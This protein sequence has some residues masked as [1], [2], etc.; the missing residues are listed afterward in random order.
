MNFDFMKNYEFFLSL[1]Y[2]T[3]LASVVTL[4]I[5]QI[6]KAIL[7][8]RNVIFPEMEASH[9]DSILSAVG[10][11]VALIAYTG[12]YIG[13]EL[14]LKHAITFDEELITGLLSGGAL[15]LTISKGFYTM[16]HQYRNKKTVYEKLRYAE[17]T[18]KKLQEPQII[19]AKEEAEAYAKNAFLPAENNSSTSKRQWTLTNRNHSKEN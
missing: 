1:G 14:Y 13:N 19:S 4:V 12:F 17:K 2:V 15:T 5:T 10:R 9:R 3:I 6:I 8:K 7:K 16:L 18:L 11:I